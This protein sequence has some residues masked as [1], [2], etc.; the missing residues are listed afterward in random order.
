MTML[1]PESWAKEE[2]RFTLEERREW[3]RDVWEIAPE[4]QDAHI[5]MFP[6]EVPERLIRMYSFVGET[7]LDPF[8]GSGTTLAAAAKHNRSAIGIELGF[9]SEQGW[10]QVVRSKL[11]AHTD[12]PVTIE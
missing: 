10:E 1:S 7:V 12:V 9:D 11:G 4:Q 8:M 6:M 3:F 2:S 5:A